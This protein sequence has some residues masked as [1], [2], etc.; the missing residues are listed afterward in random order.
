MAAALSTLAAL[1]S[2]L[3]QP[4]KTS[5]RRAAQ[6]DDS[7]ALATL[8]DGMSAEAVDDDTDLSGRNALHHA[9]WRGGIENVELLLNFGCNINRW[10]T[11]LHCYG[12]TPIF[13]AIT[14]CRDDVVDLLLDH[15][16]RTRIVNNKGQSVLSL[17]ATHLHISTCERIEA[18]EIKESAR[19][20]G[21]RPVDADPWLAELARLPSGWPVP[22]RPAIRADGWVDFQSSHPSR[23]RMDTPPRVGLDVQPGDLDPRFYPAAQRSSSDVVTRLAVN[24]TTRE[25]RRTHSHLSREQSL[26]WWPAAS[27]S[28]PS[29]PSSSASKRGAKKA[30]QLEPSVRPAPCAQHEL[31]DEELE[32][33]Y[34]EDFA[35]FHLA[36][37]EHV[38]PACAISSRF[39]DPV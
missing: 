39:W 10:S 19:Y 28:K 21:A 34:A 2:A 27:T 15:G 26:L 3:A 23:A 18:A 25:S 29:A 17:A 5:L 13:Y 6:R 11:G 37:D 35:A 38:E 30:M 31:S 8:L 4:I 12:K 33:A 7:D 24:P 20:A 1:V 9:A 32:Q 22:L 16:A 14:R 36:L